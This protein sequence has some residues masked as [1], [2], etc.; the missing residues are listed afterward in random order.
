MSRVPSLLSTRI[1]VVVPVDSQT[2]CLGC[3]ILILAIV[4]VAAVVIVIAMTST[5]T[6]IGQARIVWRPV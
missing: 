3:L 4:V 1:N 2:I 5:I 6:I